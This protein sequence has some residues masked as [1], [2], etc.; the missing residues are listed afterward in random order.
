M[1]SALKLFGNDESKGGVSPDPIK[2]P[3]DPGTNWD[4][5]RGLTSNAYQPQ[6]ASRLRT[7]LLATLLVVALGSLGL[8]LHNHMPAL[9]SFGEELSETVHRLASGTPTPS[10]ATHETTVQDVRGPRSK[11]ASSHARVP[12]FQPDQA[13]DSAFHPF[14][15][16]AVVGGRRVSLVSNNSVILVDVASGTWK[17]GSEAE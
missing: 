7:A 3:Q 10:A 11:H 13:Y 8:L 2:S 4:S 16:T 5:L 17:L 14:Y 15:A 1:T 6:R 12:D 9:V